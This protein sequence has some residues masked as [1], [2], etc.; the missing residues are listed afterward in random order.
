M[1]DS[2]DPVP[3]RT[4][5]RRLPG[6]TR[7]G[8][9]RHDLLLDAAGVTF[10]AALAVVP[11]LLVVG[12]LAALV[13]GRDSVQALAG[14]MGSALPDALGAG[15]IADAFLSYA[16]EVGW[17]AVAVAVLPATLYGEG[18]RRAYGSLAGVD[19]R[20]VGWRGRLS[21]LPVLVVA[22]ALL[23]GVLA[24]T[25]LLNDLFGDG[26]WS[27][28]LGIYVALNVD[29]LAVS[30][31]L[32]WSFLVVA[33]DAPPARIAVTGALATGTFVAGFLQGF[34]LFLSLP[35]DLGAP[36]G[37]LVPVGAVTAVLLWM[38]L[39]HVVVLVGYVATRQAAQLR[40]PAHVGG[41]D[42]ITSPRRRAQPPGP[43]ARHAARPP[44]GAAAP[45]SASP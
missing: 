4:V 19:D 18:L 3:W 22:P 26:F 32:A 14:E 2:P 30:V 31:P 42:G 10:Y 37:G 41:T 28:V 44:A 1:I 27:G 43:V 9:T 6:C 13:A 5:L 11:L 39:L 7:S 38:W 8:L 25:P 16:V 29:W 40:H 45:P 15:V 20:F 24:I 21:T 34:V 36:F 23:L 33:P 35:L 12:R 17:L